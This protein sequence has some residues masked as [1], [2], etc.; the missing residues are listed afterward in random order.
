MDNKIVNSVVQTSSPRKA[1]LTAIEK[2][3]DFGNVARNSVNTHDFVLRNDTDK[4]VII[5][6]ARAS[7][8]C[9]QPTYE[10]GK[11]LIPGDSTIVKANYTAPGN[12]GPFSKS[13]T[14]YYNWEIVETNNALPTEKK[15]YTSDH[16]QL[17]IKG[18]IV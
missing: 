11:V 7:C 15:I 8:G 9:T 3:H 18:N 6:N 17:I 12:L 4:N 14:V 10:K 5:T 1:S 16:T 13:I 2:E